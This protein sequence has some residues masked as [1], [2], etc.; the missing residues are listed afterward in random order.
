[1]CIC[2]LV[3]I[4]SL[5][6]GQGLDVL[7]IMRNIHV[8][9]SRYAY[10]LNN[11]IFVERA[12]NNKHLNTISIRHIANSIRTH[13]IGIMSTTVRIAPL[14]VGLCVLFRPQWMMS[15][16]DNPDNTCDQFVVLLSVYDFKN[17]YCMNISNM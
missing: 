9:V 17:N 1:M 2:Q 7:E 3:F 11:Q 8:F 15:L 13:G 12:S 4:M 14:P 5:S 10:N 16:P 6:V